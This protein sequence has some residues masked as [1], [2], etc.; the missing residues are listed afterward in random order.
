M[1]SETEIEAFHR[2]GFLVFERLLNSERLAHYR[3]LFDA[4]VERGRGLAASVPHFSLELDQEEKP[5]PG[6]LHKVQG[7]CQVEPRLLE[8]AGEPA[9]TDRVAML[10]GPDLDVFGT[11]FFPKLPG[12]GSSTHWHQD[13]YYFGTVSEQVLSCGIYLEDAD[14]SNGCLR[15]VPGSHLKG[16]VEHQRDPRTHGS[17][18][19]VEDEVALDLPVPAGT[20][21][22]FSA[23]LLH[24][25][26]D[27]L[28]S[29]RTRYSTAWHYV[30]GTLHLEQFPRGVYP[31]RHT[32]RGR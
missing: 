3:V 24:G 12:G 14:R 5:I 28:H 29:Q 4:L 20:V 26:N 30:P 11:K 9:I 32:V 8:L 13:N 23:N 1:L 27:N 17:W 19:Q 6:M 15:V 22:L 2:G 16:L 18:C 10:L 7:V 21:V 31:D 25:A